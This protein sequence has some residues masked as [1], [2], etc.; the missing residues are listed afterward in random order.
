[1]KKILANTVYSD[2]TLKSWNKENLIELIRILENNWAN[3][4]NSLNIQAKNCEML[5]K[6]KQEEIE[7]LKSKSSFK[8][9]WKNKFFKA[10]EEIERLTKKE[11]QDTITHIDIC[12]ENLSLRKQKAELQK[13]VKQLKIGLESEKNWGKIQKK[14]A[15]KDTAKEIYTDLLKEFSIRK[16]CGNADVVLREMANRKGVEVE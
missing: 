4:E 6:E 12:T 5:L 3:A 1:M 11:Q 16:S 2:S 9:S 10:Q 13:Q 14:Q 8:D 15:V 7:N